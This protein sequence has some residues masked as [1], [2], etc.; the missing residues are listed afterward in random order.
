LA[1]AI[2]VIAIAVAL[3]SLTPQE[4]GAPPLDDIDEASRARLDAVLRQADREEDAR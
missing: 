3:W 4:P 2:G 1:V